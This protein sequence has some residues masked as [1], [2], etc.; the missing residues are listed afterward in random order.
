M[1]HS[2]HMT[3]RTQSSFDG[4]HAHW[5]TLAS[6]IQSITGDFL[7]VSYAN[8]MPHLMS[9]KWIKTS[10]FCWRQPRRTHVVLEFRDYKGV[11]QPQAQSF[12][13]VAFSYPKRP[14][15]LE[16]HCSKLLSSCHVFDIPQQWAEFAC[17]SPLFNI[18]S[19]SSLNVDV[20]CFRLIDDEMPFQKTTRRESLDFI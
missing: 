4:R 13:Y 16:S 8:D 10:P 9:V 12:R 1:C 19:V 11:V 7:R 6:C 17:F 14:Q 5:A 15:Y 2:H 18:T 20:L 3:K